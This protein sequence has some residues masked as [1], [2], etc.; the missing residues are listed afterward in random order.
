MIHSTSLR[1]AGSEMV[2]SSWLAFSVPLPRR[3]SI[4]RLT[5]ATSGSEA[6][7]AGPCASGGPEI[8]GLL[9]AEAPEAPGRVRGRATAAALREVDLIFSDLAAAAVIPARF[10]VFATG[11][12]VA[13]GELLAPALCAALFAAKQSVKPNRL[14][15]A[16][17]ATSADRYDRPKAAVP[18]APL[19]SPQYAIT[20]YN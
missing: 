6:A 7:G 16:S 3:A 20:R 18:N 19:C 1:A 2:A 11:F 10:A 5:S 12:E 4:A 9:G 15:H 14:A 17:A 13:A 8:A